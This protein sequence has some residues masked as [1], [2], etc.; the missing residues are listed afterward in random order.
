MLWRVFCRWLQKRARRYTSILCNYT[1]ERS[2]KY[3]FKSGLFVV[4]PLLASVLAFCA[5][6]AE[7]ILHVPSLEGKPILVVDFGHGSYI[8]EMAS[9]CALPLHLYL[10]LHLFT[11]RYRLLVLYRWNKASD[12]S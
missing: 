4:P 5:P 2:Y 11:C 3:D 9:C 7:L 12:A 1:L 8:A 6:S 10:Y